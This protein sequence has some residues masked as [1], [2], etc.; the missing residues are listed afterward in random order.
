MVDK[1]LRDALLA[2][3]GA[4]PDAPD[5]ESAEIGRAHV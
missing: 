5:G 1:E 3:I 4:L 2:R